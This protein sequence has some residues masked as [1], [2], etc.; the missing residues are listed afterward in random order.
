VAPVH[1]IPFLIETLKRGAMIGFHA[2]LSGSLIRIG[3]DRRRIA[4]ERL[5]WEAAGDYVFPS[6]SDSIW[7]QMLKGAIAIEK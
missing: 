7:R 1:A 2:E 6:S 4:T 5:E 3:H